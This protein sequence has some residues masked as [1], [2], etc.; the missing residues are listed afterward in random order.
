MLMPI[1]WHRA[2]TLRLT[3]SQENS[4]LKWRHDQM[5]KWSAS[6]KKV[7]QDS[8]ALREALLNGKPESALGAFVAAVQRDQARMLDVEIDQVEYLHRL[9]SPQQWRHLIALY[10]FQMMRMMHMGWHRGPGGR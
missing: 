2:V 8:L 7:M 9:L 5:R 1:V 4:L 10:R 3:P 6:R